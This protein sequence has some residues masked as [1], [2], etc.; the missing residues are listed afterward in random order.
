MDELE[1]TKWLRFGV[2]FQRCTC[3]K[4]PYSKAD[5]CPFAFALYNIDGDCLMEK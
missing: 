5:Q 3:L 2:D 1:K 4:C